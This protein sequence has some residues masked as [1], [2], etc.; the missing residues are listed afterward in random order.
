MANALGIELSGK[1]VIFDEDTFRDEYKHLVGIPFK[2]SN[3]MGG[4]RSPNATGTGL[5]GMFANGMEDKMNGHSVT[6]VVEDD[7]ILDRM[8]QLENEASEEAHTALEDKMEHG[9]VTLGSIETLR[10][11]FFYK[12]LQA[13]GIIDAD[14]HFILGPCG[15]EGYTPKIIFTKKQKKK[16]VGI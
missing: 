9:G 4:G 5:Y 2:V 14:K 10:R 15:P 8:V 11:T 13:E 6:A 1:T 3:S 16:K 12:K 7:P